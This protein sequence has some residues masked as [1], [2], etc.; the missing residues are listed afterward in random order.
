[1][2][3]LELF[4]P[5]VGAAALGFARRAFDEARRRS[6]ARTAFRKP[7]AEF[8]LVQAKLA[9][10]AVKIDASA[11]LVYRAAWQHDA[12]EGPMRREAATAKLFATEAACEVIDQAVQIFGGLGVTRG[13]TVERLYRHARA[14]RIFDG[15][16]EI[17]QMI[18][19]REVLR[20]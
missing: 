10:M 12:G 7:L 8:Q 2:R 6:L 20:S 5:S 11:L 19:A 18:I 15:A 17:Q 1:M 14:F 4:R 13:T 9:D 16:S 3:V